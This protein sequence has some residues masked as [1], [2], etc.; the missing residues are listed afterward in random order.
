MLCLACRRPASGLCPGCRRSL[1]PAP[2][3]VVDGAVVIP[4]FRHAGAAATLVHNL[5]Y[6]RCRASGR[7][8]AEAMA[9]RVPD[10]AHC[11]VPVPRSTTR[12]LRYGIDQTAVLAREIA[13]R[14]RL[15][16]V[17]AFT[18]PIWWRRRAGMDRM[19]RRPVDFRHRTPVPPG[20]VIIDDVLTTGATVGSILRLIGH[21]EIFVITAT[22]AGTM[23]S[24]AGTDPRPG[25]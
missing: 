4:A 5:K 1:R 22:A 23:G 21:R 2:E 11:V 16:V 18:P 9:A 10:G 17:D 14:R 12:R 8:L 6:R 24:R 7:L 15:T 3:R 20:A 25:R 13:R 19:H